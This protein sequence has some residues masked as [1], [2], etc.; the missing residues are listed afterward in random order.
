MT[1]LQH[2]SRDKNFVLKFSC[3]RPMTKRESNVVATLFS[4][5][6]LGRI[7]RSASALFLGLFL[8]L[9]AM[10][11][12]PALHALLHPD[13]YDSDHECAVTLFT[14]GQVDVSTPDVAV[15][16]APIIVHFAQPA[17]SI[18]F[19]STDV[20]LMPGRGPPGFPALV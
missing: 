5:K 20:S 2:L 8:S 12:L 13:A 17:P 18:I 6:A 15:V 1:K 9:Q 4:M 10:A 14:H 11:I 19:V 3:K 7:R 16:P